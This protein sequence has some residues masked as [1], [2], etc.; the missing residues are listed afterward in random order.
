MSGAAKQ[1][2][3][4]RIREALGEPAEAGVIPRGYRRHGADDVD[5]GELFA[6]RVADY[7]AVIW[8]ADHGSVAAT[9]SVALHARGARRIAIPADLP[10]AW[11]AAEGFVLVADDPPLTADVLNGIDAVVTGCAVAV[12]ETGTIVLEGGPNQ[13]RRALTLLPDIHVC[14]VELDQIVATVSEALVRLD[15]HRPSTW[16]SGP[17]ATSDIELRR[18][19]GVHGPRQLDVVIVQP[20]RAPAAK[21]SQAPPTP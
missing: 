8:R 14:V 17:S 13:G 18:V 6:T 21:R 19:E 12:A 15:P 5:Q 9:V 10:S 20:P 11:I 2:V 4:C 16:I 7:R 3:L 1:A